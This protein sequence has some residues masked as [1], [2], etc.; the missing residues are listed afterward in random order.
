MLTALEV[1][2][3]AH[4]GFQHLVS[5]LELLTGTRLWHFNPWSFCHPLARLH[6]PL[7]VKMMIE[8]RQTLGA[9]FVVPALGIAQAVHAL[10]KYAV[11]AVH[12]QVDHM[13]PAVVFA[14]AHGRY[15]CSLI[16][17]LA[18]DVESYAWVVGLE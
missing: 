13:L 17:V 9:C 8:S 18:I 10:N 6:V 5:D 16:S 4:G 15:F 1:R 12:E 11:I 14:D 3:A 2:V 7:Q